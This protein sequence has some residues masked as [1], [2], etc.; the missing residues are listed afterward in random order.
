[1]CV[2]LCLLECI[3][4]WI[5]LFSIFGGENIVFLFLF[6]LV[7]IWYLS[8]ESFASSVIE[9][10]VVKNLKTPVVNGNTHIHIETRTNKLVYNHQS[11]I[12]WVEG[13]QQICGWSGISTLKKGYLSDIPISLSSMPTSITM[14]SFL[15]RC[16][17]QLH[18]LF[19]LG[20][21]LAFSLPIFPHLQNRTEI[22]KY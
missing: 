3:E 19:H 5:I 20:S 2:N 17:F 10:N 18:H 6:M 4:I 16:W 1:M 9:V 8:T 21:L 15:S 22:A 7:W 13:M 14:N 11:R 12:W